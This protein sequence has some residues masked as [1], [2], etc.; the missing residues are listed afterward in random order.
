MGNQGWKIGEFAKRA[1]L[2]V[3]TLHHYDRI[4]LF[5]PS[6]ATESGHRLYTEEDVRTLQQILALKQLGF[7]LEEIRAMM[8]NPAYNPS[9]MLELQLSRLNGQI[10]ALSDLRDRVKQLHGL[11]Q[12]GQSVSAEQFM[13]VIQMMNMLQSPH[14]KP[15]ELRQLRSRYLSMGTEERNLSGVKGQ[16]LL[17]EF[18]KNLETGK[19]PDDPEVAVLAERWK[20]EMDAIA[21]NDAFVR[22]AEEYYRENPDEGLY[23]GMDGKLYAYIRQA[24]SRLS[25]Q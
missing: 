1:G 2:T 17:A 13:A 3:R 23:H 24:V 5:S 20:R 12:S 11:L 15:G 7:A 16:Q 21:P 4:G 25:F 22:S 14:F 10:G 6:R 9:E 18:R 8:N 19:P